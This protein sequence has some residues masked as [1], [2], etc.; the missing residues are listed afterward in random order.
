MAKLHLNAG[1]NTHKH[2]LSIITTCSRS[3]HCQACATYYTH[4]C[5]YVL[6]LKVRML[7]GLRGA[8]HVQMQTRTL[9]ATRLSVCLTR[10]TRN[11]THLHALITSVGFVC[12]APA[13]TRQDQ[14][15]LVS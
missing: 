12:M 5:S 7:R 10:D 9:A 2:L 6:A 11:D 8:R 3:T 14:L 13:A 15:K 4:Q 1:T